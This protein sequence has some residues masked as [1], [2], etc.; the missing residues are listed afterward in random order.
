MSR[1]C[2]QRPSDDRTHPAFGLRTPGTSPCL[3]RTRHVLPQYRRPG[4][5]RPKPLCTEVLSLATPAASQGPSGLTRQVRD[6]DPIKPALPPGWYRPSASRIGFPHSRVPPGV[7]LGATDPF[8]H[9]IQRACPDCPSG[10]WSQRSAPVQSRRSRF[11]S[12]A[13]RVARQRHRTI[14]R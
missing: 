7:T 9:R 3:H 6:A 8:A 12:T 13:T 1:N 10:T 14:L 4:E 11:T 2:G 5:E